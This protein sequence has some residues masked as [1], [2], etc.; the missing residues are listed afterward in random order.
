MSRATANPPPPVA[1]NPCPFCQS[2]E[3]KVASRL[4]PVEKAK[5]HYAQ[6]M[7]CGATGSRHLSHRVA[8]L[9]WN[10]VVSSPDPAPTFTCPHCGAMHSRGPEVGDVYRCIV[11][12]TATRKRTAADDEPLAVIGQGEYAR[13]IM[14][15]ETNLNETW[16]DP[17]GD[18][19]YEAP[20]KA[21][22]VAAWV[23]WAL[24][25]VLAIAAVLS[26]PYGR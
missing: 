24:L 9:R 6:C 8:L 13:T 7:N 19:V 23:I 5:V 20:A 25:A 12:G 22:E 3:V 11:C 15:G 4:D 16:E 1:P 26:F 21:S 18:G 2:V 17:D 10:G 14:P